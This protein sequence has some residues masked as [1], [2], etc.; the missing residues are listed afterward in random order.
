VSGFKIKTPSVV[1]GKVDLD[2]IANLVARSQALLP[3]REPVAKTGKS[4]YSIENKAADTAEVFIYDVIGDWGVSASD[5]VNDLKA[6]GSPKKITL[7]INSEG[8][9][10]FDGIAIFEALARS[11][12]EI[13]GFV[14]GLA[15]SAASFIAMAADHLTV[16][17]NAK[18]MI[19][20]A[21]TIAWGNPAALRQVADLLDELS[22][23]IADVYAEKS[24]KPAADWRTAMKAETWYSAQK[25]VDEGLADEV[26]PSAASRITRQKDDDSEAEDAVDITTVT[27][28]TEVMGTIASQLREAFA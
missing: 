26:G 16:A 28:S 10:V 3:E 13:A 14:D 24:G 6:L 23:T 4:W 25:A 15:A 11:E 2:R 12:A 17:R 27:M 8:G 19:H 9:E 5:F 21:S 7:R 20:D 22:D 18:M 1:P